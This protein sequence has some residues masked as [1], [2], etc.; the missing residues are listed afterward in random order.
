MS[1]RARG[2]IHSGNGPM[3]CSVRGAST[4]IVVTLRQC[5]RLSSGVRTTQQ[6]SARRPSVPDP[7]FRIPWERNH[8]RWR[9]HSRTGCMPSCTVS[10]FIVFGKVRPHER[11]IYTL[12]PRDPA[13]C[14]TKIHAPMRLGNA[15]ELPVQGPRWLSRYKTN[16]C[17]GGWFPP[18][19]TRGRVDPGPCMK[20]HSRGRG[21]DGEAAVGPLEWF[22]PA[23]SLSSPRSM[24]ADLSPAD[25]P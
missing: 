13:V 8:A 23:R 17:D 19:P 15:S 20:Y 11:D 3:K 12:P 6:L 24:V 25:L 16:A 9:E 5:V 14:F 21:G 18:T 2:N 10:G 22:P 7:V 4:G 1:T